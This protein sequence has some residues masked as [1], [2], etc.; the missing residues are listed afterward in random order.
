VYATRCRLDYPAS[1][2]GSFTLAGRAARLWPVLP[3]QSRDTR[4]NIGGE[5]VANLGRTQ[6]RRTARRKISAWPVFA[7]S[8][9]CRDWR[10]FRPW[11]LLLAFILVPPC[12]CYRILAAGAG[13]QAVARRQG[14][15]WLM[16]ASV[17]VAE[18][19]AGVC[20]LGV[21]AAPSCHRG[22]LQQSATAMGAWRPFLCQPVLLCSPCRCSGVFERAISQPLS[23]SPWIKA[24]RKAKPVGTWRRRRWACCSGAC[25]VG[26]A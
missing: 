16:L 24:G 5:A 25:C 26:P 23:G 21:L 7:S 13:G 10:V 1:H 8:G 19:G 11:G 9:R 3:P 4:G 12:R 15:G 22:N 2:T 17:Y 20:S 6:G 14:A 18:H